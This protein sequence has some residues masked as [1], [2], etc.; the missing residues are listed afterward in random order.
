VLADGK[1]GDV[2]VTAT[3]YG[4]ALGRQHADAVRRRAR[5]EVDAFTANPLLGET[6]S[7]R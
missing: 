3:A 7:A 1:R 5:L 2:P 6:R 4:Q